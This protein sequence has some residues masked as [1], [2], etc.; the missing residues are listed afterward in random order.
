MCGD[1]PC[2]DAITDIYVSKVAQS[3]AA[4]DVTMKGYKSGVLKTVTK[5]GR[6]I[7]AQLGFTSNYFKTSSTSDISTL[8]VGPVTVSSTTTST[9][10]S[11]TE[12]EVT[13]TTGDTPQYATSSQ[14]L[15]YLSTAGLLNKCTNNA[16]ACQAKII[17]REEAAAVVAIVGGLSLDSPNAY[18]DDDESIYQNAINAVP[19]YGMHVCFSSPFE[20]LPKESVLRDQFACMLH[21]AIKQGTANDLEGT[22]D[23]YSDE[24]GSSHQTA[25]HTLAANDLIP[26]CSSITDKFCPSRKISIGEVSYMINKLVEKNL[27]DSN[28]FN[29]TPFQQGWSPSGGEVEDAATTAVSNPNS[30]ND[31]CVAKDNTNVKLDNTLDIQRFLSDNGFNPGPIDGKPGNKTKAAIKE[32]QTKNGLLADGIVGN[33]TKAAMRSYTGCEQANTCKARDNTNVKLDSV[34]DIQTYLSNNGFNPGIIDGEMGS[35]TKEAIKAFQ[36]EVGLIPDGVA[37]R[38]TKA[39][40]RSYTGC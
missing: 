36:R 7:K 18:S 31:A 29:V 28:V 40:M 26:A 8:N 11:T 23:P 27:I 6:N 38:R 16:S 19:Y 35:Y 2:F 21:R 33:K 9:T 32:F 25:I 37:G 3:G 13:S 17:T 22:S 1:V 14:G 12:A 5:S 30:G 20:Y 34:E 10:T 39:E 4:I 15:N 24:G